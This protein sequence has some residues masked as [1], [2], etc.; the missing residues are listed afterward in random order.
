MDRVAR[1]AIVYGVA[2]AHMKE[3]TEHAPLLRSSFSNMGRGIENQPSHNLVSD[4]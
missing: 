4:I 2:E 3:A 1:R